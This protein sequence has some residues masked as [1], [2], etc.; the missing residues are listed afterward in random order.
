MPHKLSD[1]YL[2]VAKA[3][4]GRLVKVFG[5]PILYHLYFNASYRIQIRFNSKYPLLWMLIELSH[6][7]RLLET[8]FR[9]LNCS[10]GIRQIVT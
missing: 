9:K 3:F 2:E 8:M 4:P 7:E 10:D 1:E 6:K 5:V